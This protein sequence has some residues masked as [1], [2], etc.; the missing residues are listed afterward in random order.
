LE[1]NEGDLLAFPEDENADNE[2]SLE[3]AEE[4]WMPG[5]GSEWAVAAPLKN[6]HYQDGK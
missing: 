6:F 1:V 5:K 4:G 2:N 3:K